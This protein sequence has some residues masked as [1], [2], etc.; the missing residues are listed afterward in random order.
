M[1]AKRKKIITQLQKHAG[2]FLLQETH[3]DDNLIGK[4][5]RECPGT[6][7]HAVGTT[8]SRGV[9]IF[10]S[11]K[12]KQ[13]S[14]I[15]GSYFDSTDG[16]IVGLGVTVGGADILLVSVYA[17]NAGSSTEDKNKQRAFFEALRTNISSALRKR[18]YLLV[19][20]GDLNFIRDKV[21]DA[22]GGNPVEHKPAIGAL[23]KLEHDFCLTDM[24][25]FLHE[26]QSLFTWTA[27]G[28]FRRLDYFL[29]STALATGVTECRTVPTIYSDHKILKCNLDIEG[30]EELGRGLWKHNNLLLKEDD[31]IEG[32]TTT[33]KEAMQHEGDARQVWEWIKFQAKKKAR[34]FSSH[35]AGRERRR[36]EDVEGRLDAL[37]ENPQAEPREVEEA[38]TQLDFFYTKEQETI[39]FRAG[40]ERVESGEKVTP[41][42]FR[43]IKYNQTNSN[44]TCLKNSS[45]QETKNKQEVLGI[46]HNYF[47]NIFQ[48]RPQS[49][50]SALWTAEL[51]KLTEVSQEALQLPIT[52]NELTTALF[53]HCHPGKSP[54]NDGLTVSFYRKFWKLLHQP[55]FEM[56][57]E[58]WVRGQL[59]DSQK[60]STIKLLR[61]KDKDPTELTGWR[62]ISLMNC[63]AKMYAKAIARRL[64]A[65]LP[66]LISR[67]QIAYLGGRF[68][69]ESALVLDN[70]INVAVEE[71]KEAFLL[72][73][74]FKAAFDSV[75]HSYLWATMEE[76]GIPEELISHVKTL[77]SGAESCVLNYG[78]TTRFFDLERSTRQGDPVAPYLF[79]IAVE[80]LLRR[81]KKDLKGIRVGTHDHKACAFADD[82]T[83]ITS[84]IAELRHAL[85]IIRQFGDISGLRINIKKSEIMPLF[86]T[87][88]TEIEGIRIVNKL[89]ICGFYFSC[90]KQRTLELNW[91]AVLTKVKNKFQLWQGRNL[92]VVGKSVIINC[93]IV[94][95][96]NYTAAAL[97]LPNEWDKKLTKLIF[98]FLWKGPG[99]KRTMAYKDWSEGGVKAPFLRA[100]AWAGKLRWI[101][102]LRKGEHGPWTSVFEHANIDWTDFRTFCS[103]IP[104]KYYP[105]DTFAHQCVRAWTDMLTLRKP[106]PWTHSYVFQNDIFQSLSNED[107]T[108]YGFQG[109]PS[110]EEAKNDLGLLRR[111][112]LLPF[113]I[114]DLHRDL[115]RFAA[116][117]EHYYKSRRKAFFVR[118]FRGTSG[119]LIRDMKKYS[120]ASLDILYSHGL[121]NQQAIYLIDNPLGQGSRDHS[122]E[123]YR[124]DNNPIGETSLG[125]KKIRDAYWMIAQLLP[126]ET[127]PFRQ[128]IDI[129]SEQD[130]T[131]V[132]KTMTKLSNYSKFKAFL[133]RS[134][135]GLLYANKDFHRFKYRLDDECKICQTNVT[136]D[137]NHLYVDCAIIQQLFHK[138]ETVLGLREKLSDVEKLCGIDTALKRHCLTIKKINILRK[139]VYD[140]NTHE[141]IPKWEA[142]SGLLNRIYQ[143]EKDI[144]ARKGKLSTHFRLWQIN[145][146]HDAV[147]LL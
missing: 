107:R 59:T 16:R 79:L 80:P 129:A 103:P 12:L 58:A 49:E 100:L 105:E 78:V 24:Q 62:P 121:S 10:L 11:K 133:F 50:L 17:P 45:N 104:D 92:S 18:K 144:A 137:L 42:F 13:T 91:D 6:W 48:H 40:V 115:S 81:L 9:S 22:R 110:I 14:V 101:M 21:L 71:K 118:M 90:S 83:A 60:Q 72:A 109:G 84:N 108:W 135:H 76:M 41:Y 111:L 93:Q 2:I 87:Q 52:K 75:S 119:W 117:Q 55:Y 27:R 116:M 123:Y 3:F 53:Q 114:E 95:I 15:E 36:R 131:V 54:G 51:P 37:L 5:S 126:T 139:F 25:R 112:G 146:E 106:A 46:I 65:V 143:L 63:D 74:D 94:P 132:D 4:V 127:T 97:D 23:E 61:K 20:G 125:I 77:Y 120:E 33:I 86:P 30:T 113:E 39:S 73:V 88:L 43:T 66:E 19:I 56:M 1:T 44:V 28:K 26:D 64:Q 57:Q 70:V 8:Q 69:A 68:V 142:F 34:A 99:I 136:Q 141:E 102:K 98:K 128:R 38:K 140:C 47:S 35:K 82:V 85:E 29:I 32:M 130:W 147:L 138:F 145:T 67:E 31:Y 7:V 96:I 122:N 124:N 134:S 89:K